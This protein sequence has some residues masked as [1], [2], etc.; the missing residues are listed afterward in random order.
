MET[1]LPPK[2]SKKK[3]YIIFAVI[4]TLVIV[5]GVVL[6]LILLGKRQLIKQKASVPGGI[7]KISISPET[8]TINEGKTFTAN[9]FFDSAGVAVSALTTQIEYTY[10]GDSPPISA[11]QVQINSTLPVEHE[12]KFPVKSISDDNGKVIIRIAG[13]CNSIDGY[14]TSGQEQLAS[15]SFKGDSPGSIS[16]Q[17]DPTESIIT[18][19]SNSSDILLVP[20]STGKYTV[21]GSSVTPTPSPEEPTPSPEEPTPTPPSGEFTPIPTPAPI[22]E[23]GFSAPAVFGAGL[24]GLLIMGAIF[25]T[26]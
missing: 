25:L 1:T 23:T 22:P 7:A 14:T 6:G 21:L 2:S 8:K 16:V 20:Q 11:T 10:Q 15:I 24:G 4:S 5:M 13:F 3:K 18:Q 17:F 26:I 12:W 19:K 9:V